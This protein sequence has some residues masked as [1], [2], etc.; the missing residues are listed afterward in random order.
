MT[1]K[2]DGDIKRELS[3]GREAY[4]LTLSPTGFTFVLKG[5]PRGL[6]IKWVERVSGDA[7]LA[8]ALTASLRANILRP[9]KQARRGQDLAVAAPGAF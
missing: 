7:A 5:R 2:L 4:T 8:T 1:T 6:D 3:I 9:R